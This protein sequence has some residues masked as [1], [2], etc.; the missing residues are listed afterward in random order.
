MGN[1]QPEEHNLSIAIKHTIVR[2][3]LGLLSLVKVQ[4]LLDGPGN[5]FQR[6]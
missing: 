5:V 6:Q 1:A 2:P 3:A 4:Y